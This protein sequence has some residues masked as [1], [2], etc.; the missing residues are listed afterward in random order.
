MSVEQISRH[1]ETAAFVEVWNTKP[2]DHKPQVVEEIAS[3]V[4]ETQGIPDL[5]YFQADR[6]GDIYSP[7]AK[8]KV[9]EAILREGYIGS[10]EGQ[11]FDRLNEWFKR[12][13]QGVAVWISPIYKG[14]Y[15][16]LKIVISEIEK[17]GSEKLLSNRAIIFDYN[18]QQGLN[19]AKALAQFSLNKPTFTTNEQVRS[20]PVILDTSDAHWTD[21]LQNLT[22]CSE[23]WEM[24]RRED[25]KKAKASMLANADVWYE[26]QF[27]SDRW[28]ANKP[29]LANNILLSMLGTRPTSCPELL[30]RGRVDSLGN[31][32]P[33]QFFFESST[34][35]KKYPDFPCPNESCDQII[36]SGKGIEEC[37]KCHAKK[38]DYGN[39]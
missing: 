32:T 16:D 4:A 31:L 18:E 6:D 38:S 8:R 24:I 19:F 14:V 10:V 13:E 25:D 35:L 15:P 29:N 17:R 33:F 7:A 22:G 5:Y 20:T 9:S 30:K 27:G 2:L 39:C 11:T 28:V 26:K 36:E 34:L 12:N 21:I 1:P 23:I 3:W 37:P